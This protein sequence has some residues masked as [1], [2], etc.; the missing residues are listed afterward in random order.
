MLFSSLVFIFFYLP[1][2]IF[3][4]YIFKKRSIKNLI[5][6]TFSLFFY[7]WGEPIYLFLML[8]SISSN[9][10][11]AIFLDKHRS[12]FNKHMMLLAVA[13]NVGF[14][15]Y[16]KYFNFFIT[17]INNIFSLKIEFNEV[18]LPIGIS[19]YT[20]QILS[21]VIDVY[22]KKVEPQ[23]NILNLAM[24]VSL[25]PQLI[26]GPIV[27]YET[28]ENE[29]VNRSEN[30]DDFLAGFKRFIIGLGKKVLI[31]NNMALIA[32]T[33]MSNDISRMSSLW[34][35]IGIVAYSFQIF[36][37]FSGYSDMAIGLGKM[38]GF[39]FLENFNYPYIA[40]N[41]TDFWRRWHISL[42]TWFRDYLYI[43][44]GG[45][46]VS[47]FKWY[48]NIFVVWLIT[49]LWHG[50]SWN[51]VIWGLYFGTI[52]I[53]EKYFIIKILQLIPNFFS[54]FYSIILIIIGWVIFRLEDMSLVFTYLKGMFFI[55]KNESLYFY[56]ENLNITNSFIYFIPA[57]ILSTP[58]IKN[59]ID[60]N[61][62]N[63]FFIL[64]Y[65]TSL[66]FIFLMCIAKLLTSSYN[67]FIY[68]RF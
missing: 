38:F 2:L 68:F 36:F 63:Q 51:F 50:A 64:L 23:K 28:V 9:Y 12:N 46:K 8:L 7:S 11:I 26:A 10:L 44:M 35:W 40:K 67:P 56:M 19:F 24:Y 55:N 16:F 49:G 18:M 58:L 34:L 43:P 5:L 37:D 1:L 54:H 4:Y 3:F 48:R 42:S 47:Q 62:E 6:L 53:L 33:I 21:Y 25:F 60:K 39:N 61:K 57:I 29:I 15:F 27:R 22:R 59:I 20:F 30:L 32:D 17:N 41:I 45:N 13:F 31:A 66:I 52:L 65:N 14:L